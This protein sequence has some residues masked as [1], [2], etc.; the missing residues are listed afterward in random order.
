MLVI[1]LIDTIR[2]WVINIILLLLLLMFLFANMGYYLFGDG[3]KE[4][5]GSLGAAMLTLFNYVTVD[6]WTD[7][8]VRWESHY[9]C[10]W[11]TS[12][13]IDPLLPPFSLLHH[14]LSLEQP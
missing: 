3:D 5:W 4:N 6:G 1:A 14:S 9:C 13:V 10:L 8:Q 2:R 7:I 12:S 11:R